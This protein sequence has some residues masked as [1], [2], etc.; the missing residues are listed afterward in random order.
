MRNL[1]ASS[2]A[3]FLLIVG[4][5]GFLAFA[6]FLI[7]TKILDALKDTEEDLTSRAERVASRLEESFQQARERL[8][9]VALNP[10]VQVQDP[11]IITDL[12]TEVME[13]S[14]QYEALLVIDHN[15]SLIAE[16]P[17]GVHS[18]CL[19]QVGSLLD[20]IQGCRILSVN[21]TYGVSH[22]VCASATKVRGDQNGEGR[23]LAALADLEH[24]AE[25][26]LLDNRDDK[27]SLSIDGKEEIVLYDP[28]YGSTWKSAPFI[29]TVLSHSV[30]AETPTLRGTS[31][32]LGPEWMI[33]VSKPYG[34]FLSNFAR[35]NLSIQG[36]FALLFFPVVII[37]SIVMLAI[38]HSRRYFK[39]LAIRDGLTGLYN[40]RFFQTALQ[41][42]VTKQ[43]NTS[44]SLLMIDIDDFKFLND[45]HGHQAGDQVLIEL[46]DILSSSIRDTDIAA[47][48][49][50]E[51]FTVI[52]PGI[53][54]KEAFK[55]AERIG[56]RVKAK[57]KCTV[58][59]GVSSLPEHASTIED[60]IRGADQALYRAKSLSKD[61]A[62]GVW[63]LGER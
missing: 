63:E 62:I 16:V 20:M 25:T 33:T 5:L 14:P 3:R 21:D 40:H 29:L 37:F 10:L 28:D 32:V 27:I 54:P 15:G 9:I 47:R 13:Q 43:D 39:E 12:L 41:A 53:G 50:G 36:F 1:A 30:K 34:L 35:D 19:T 26:A 38:N 51:E 48:Y 11:Q 49:G 7:S 2:H 6:G 42:E 59:I 57:G 24:I 58:S 23:F 55:V 61:R 44:I 56:N 18:E 17:T 4:L 22:Y 46:A 8:E 31:V 52:L 60:L 45:T